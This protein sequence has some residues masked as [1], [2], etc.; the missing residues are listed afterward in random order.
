MQDEMRSTDV[1]ASDTSAKRPI[2]LHYH[3]RVDADTFTC[4]C[5]VS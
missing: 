5:L 3:A 2:Y 1:V 4:D